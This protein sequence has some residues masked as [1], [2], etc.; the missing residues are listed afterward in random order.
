VAAG[1]A[2]GGAGV[3]PGGRLLFAL[4]FA[5]GSHAWFAGSRR[6]HDSV[7]DALGRAG[8]AKG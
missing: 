8:T 2:R 1:P 3:V 7:A 5:D 4:Q 6:D